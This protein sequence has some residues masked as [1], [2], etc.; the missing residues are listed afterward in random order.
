MSPVSKFLTV[1]VAAV[2]AVLIVLALYATN[3]LGTFNNV[4]ATPA[5]ASEAC[6]LGSIDE[7]QTKS[8]EIGGTFASSKTPEAFKVIKD[9]GNTLSPGSSDEPLVKEEWAK[10]T[11]VGVYVGPQGNSVLFMFDVKGCIVD[12]MLGVPNNT[13]KLQ[14][15]HVERGT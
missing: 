7:I 14:S 3:N 12:Y 8:S 13:P 4:L 1:A 6:P 15:F 9:Y 5:A 2:A 11:E 10:T